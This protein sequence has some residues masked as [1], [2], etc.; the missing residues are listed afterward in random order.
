MNMA[1]AVATS[2]LPNHRQFERINIEQRD[3]MVSVMSKEAQK[4][5]LG[6]LNVPSLMHKGKLVMGHRG[7]SHARGYIDKMVKRD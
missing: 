1:H 2:E 7:E 4:R 3:P 5:G 6:G